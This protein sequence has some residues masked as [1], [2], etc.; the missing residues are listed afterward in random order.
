MKKEKR[1]RE[2]EIQGLSDSYFGTSYIFH[3]ISFVT[4]ERDYRAS[5]L[6]S[7]TMSKQFVFLLF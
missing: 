5:V 3:I 6:N 4:G 1:E 7:G 2:E